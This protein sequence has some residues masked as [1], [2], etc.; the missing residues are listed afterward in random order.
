LLTVCKVI[1]AAFL[2]QKRARSSSTIVAVAAANSTLLDINTRTSLTSSSWS[3]GW[4][5][6]NIFEVGFWWNIHHSTHTIV[7]SIWHQQKQAIGGRAGTSQYWASVSPT[8]WPQARADGLRG[9]FAF[10]E[11]A[12]ARSWAHQH[13]LLI[14]RRLFSSLI[15]G[16][17]RSAQTEKWIITNKKYHSTTKLLFIHQMQWIVIA[18]A[19]KICFITKASLSKTTSNYCHV[20]KLY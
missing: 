7:T 12:F 3:R 5:W 19:V 6:W 17:L 1:R 15:V 9:S 8:W 18:D 20:A 2:C 4:I 10:A 11:Q 14:S 16:Y 13:T